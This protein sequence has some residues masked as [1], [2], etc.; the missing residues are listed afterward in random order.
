[1]SSMT[2]PAASKA[3]ASPLSMVSP[4]RTTASASPLTMTSSLA[5]SPF[6]SSPR[7]PTLVLSNS[8][9]ALLVSSSSKSLGTSNSG[10][11][12]DRSGKKKYVKQVT[13]RHNDTK[14]HLAAQHEDSALVKQIFEEIDAQMMET[15]GPEEFNVEVAE[16]KSEIVTEVNELGETALFIAAEKGNLDVVKELLKY[17]N[18]E[19]LSL[20]NRSGFNALHIAA[21]NG[22]QGRYDWINVFYI[23][24]VQLEQNKMKFKMKFKVAC[25]FCFYNL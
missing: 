7:T 1:M 5:E 24:F 23:I 17:T 18:N 16:I 11:R 25:H 15:V 2:I 19:A 10:K 22:H 6:P 13:G 3:I 21:S 8:G 4:V 9:N 20:K 14:L 12:F